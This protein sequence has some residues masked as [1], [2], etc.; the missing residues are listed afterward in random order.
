MLIM[1][2]RQLCAYV[3]CPILLAVQTANCSYFVALD[4]NNINV[5]TF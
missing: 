2:A 5:D 3:I 4:I 1:A